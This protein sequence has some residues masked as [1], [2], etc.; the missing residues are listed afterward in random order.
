[1]DRWPVG[2]VVVA[3]GLA[4]LA[5]LAVPSRAGE[6]AKPRGPAKEPPALLAPA[7]EG[8]PLRVFVTAD[9]RGYIE[10]CGCEKGQFGGLPRRGTLFSAARR[11]QDLAID[12]GNFAAGQRPLDRLKLRYMLEGLETLR[13][14]VL[15]PGEGEIALG[16]D[17]EKAASALR[18]PKVICANLVRATDGRPVYAPSVVKTL[19]DG[20]TVAVIGVTSPSQP[21][22]LEYR[23][24]P[25]VAA[26]K[27]EVSRLP[28]RVGAV[29]VAA[30]LE[31]KPAL[32]LAAE[33]PDLALVLAG[34]VPKGTETVLRRGGAPGMFAAEFGQYVAWVDLDGTLTATSSGQLWLG[35]GVPDSVG[36]AALVSR[37]MAQARELGPEFSREAVAR[38]KAEGRAGSSACKECHP[39]EF[40]AW[41]AS[42]HAR[43]MATL[44]AK[45]EDG[46]AECLTC[47]LQDS[48]T[49]D[50][51]GPS[52]RSVGCEA[53]HGPARRHVEFATAGPPAVAL[54]LMRL[55]AA[56]SCAKC[57]DGTHSKAFAFGPYWEK[58][59]HGSTKPEGVR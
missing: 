20:R 36:L 3:L 24:V 15:V 47:H 23:V 48:G 28:A 14:D 7:D 41:A 4:A 19:P 26:V 54:R 16:G 34:R 17:F 58:V 5:N 38:F 12:L 56:T 51:Q 42:P 18:G 55:D 9:A 53:C 21:I 6:E 33:C 32:D 43:T 13:Y 30:H 52:S 10:P 29:V 2:L 57:H 11:P 46:N 27:E 59:R 49:K 45:G 22:P 1:M 50:E 31:G 25:V 39:D 40:A 8:V 44:K 35:D 37:Y